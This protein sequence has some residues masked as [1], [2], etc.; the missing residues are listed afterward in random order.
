MSTS[1]RKIQTLVLCTAV[2]VSAFL[3]GILFQ[4]STKRDVDKT[5]MPPNDAPTSPQ[6]SNNGLGSPHP[7]VQHL[8]YRGCIYLDYNAT[9]PVFPE[10]TQ[11]I[12]P[13]ITNCHGNPSST[14]VYA[15]P[16][17]QA[18]QEARLFIGRL[19]NAPSPLETIYMSSCGSEA[20]NR[21]IDIA[22][23]H[24]RSKPENANIVP[25]IVTCKT[26]HPAVICYLRI[27]QINKQ[28]LMQAVP[29]DSEG[30]VDMDIFAASLTKETALVTIM[31]S[32][33]EVGTI[34][35]IGA[36]SQVIQRF[37]QA[38][39]ADILLH[40]DAAQSLGKVAVDVQAL[41]VDM[42]TIVGHKFGAPKGIGALYVNNRVQ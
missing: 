18:I 25:K 8:P 11:K 38:N 15:R 12:L 26:E 4:R 29:V 17:S 19:I 28:I 31:H 9:S 20:D 27:L 39:G 23:H 36:I 13:F 40:S 10:V 30:F 33:N 1:D 14:H 34:Q 41:S 37:N 22:L 6:V 24:F 2:G 32:N 35:P 7:S 5:L 3:A 16:C 42:L 21:A